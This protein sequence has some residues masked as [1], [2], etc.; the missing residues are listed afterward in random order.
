MVVC[1]F[2]DYV[3]HWIMDIIWILGSRSRNFTVV[4][5][6]GTCIALWKYAVIIVIGLLPQGNSPIILELF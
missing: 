4:S 5:K 1:Q 2:I 3:K 6:E